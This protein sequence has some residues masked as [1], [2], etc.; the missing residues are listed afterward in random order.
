MGGDI[1]AWCAWRG[2]TV[3][4]SDVDPKPIAGAVKRAYDLYVKIGRKDGIKIRDAMDRLIP[5]LKGEGIAS[6]DLV[7]EAA[8]EKPALKEAIYTATEPRMK[9]DAI[10]ATNTSSIPLATLAGHL[11]RPERFVGVHFFN[12]VSRMQLVEVVRHDGLAPEVEALAR[13]FVGL[14][15]RLPAPA[16]SAPGFIVNRALTPYLAEALVMLDEGIKPEVIDK[17]A[18]DFGMPMGPI[19]LADTVGLDIAVAVADSLKRDLGW[20]VPD[21]PQ[22]LRQKVADKKLGRKT[23]EGIYVWKE[24]KPV[25][26][27]ISRDGPQPDAAMADRLILP[28]INTAV[29]L[30]REGVSD[31]DDVVDAAMIFGTGFA[32]FTG[33]PL[34]YA[35]QRGAA[36]VRAKLAELEGK[37]GERFRPDAGWEGRG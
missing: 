31:S 26:A 32:P 37:Y 5:D 35:K 9:A 20:A 18:L 21:V 7:I 36:E 25:K 13:G 23:G 30:R 12:P 1:A 14:I 28:L 22:W 2:L 6:A 16:R 27:L 33:G 11:K 34:H 24:G 29:A 8:P 17:A 3:T 15:D 10:L 19:E 4:L